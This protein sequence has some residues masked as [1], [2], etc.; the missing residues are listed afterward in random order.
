[1]IPAAALTVFVTV[2]VSGGIDAGCRVRETA[3]ELNCRGARSPGWMSTGG[4]SGLLCNGDFSRAPRVNGVWAQA[5]TGHERSFAIATSI[6]DKHNSALKVASAS[7]G[8]TEAKGRQE[9]GCYERFPARRAAS[10]VC[11]ISKK[12]QGRIDITRAY[13]I[14]SKPLLSAKPDRPQ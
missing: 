2:S 11:Y 8:V 4:R 9:H 14:G 1:L 7:S 12:A 10:R 5:E 13:S 6:A 3:E